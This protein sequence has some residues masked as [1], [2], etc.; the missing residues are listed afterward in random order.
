MKT[1]YIDFA[2]HDTANAISIV[3]ASAYNTDIEITDPTIEVTGP[4]Y[5]SYINKEYQPYQV[6]VVTSLN[7]FNDLQCKIL[8]DG[9]YT[10]RM[11]VCPNNSLYKAKKHLR[12]HNL[13]TEIYRKAKIELAKCNEEA[14]HKML[15]QLLDVDIAVH[16]VACG[17]EERGT[18]LYNMIYKDV[19]QIKPV[20]VGDDLLNLNLTD[21]QHNH[22]CDCI[23]S[24]T[25]LPTGP[26]G[27]EGPMGP[28]GPKGAIGNPQ[29]W[30]DGLP[31]YVSNAAA[32]A[33]GLSIG[34][35][36]LADIGHLGALPG[37]PIKILV[38]P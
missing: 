11:S 12:V 8:G 18:A 5:N 14:A 15:T 35:Y 16:F 25:L 13:K 33:G 3:D 23:A 37:T 26:Q 2:I 9:V 32:V 27:P 4:N 10:I 29:I 36:Y 7:L 31:R 20:H 38:N 17:D 30:L 24:S 19:F 21:M 22:D 34:D 1:T 6:F 28:Q